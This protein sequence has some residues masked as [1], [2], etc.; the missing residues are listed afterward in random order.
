[1][2]ISIKGTKAGITFGK[3]QGFFIRKRRPPM[4]WFWS[5]LFPEVDWDT[6]AFT[7]G[8]TIY[9]MNPLD[10]RLTAHEKM[11]VRQQKYSRVF[12]FFCIL[13]YKFSRSY[14]KRCELE[15]HRAELQFRSKE[16][17]AKSLSG[18]LY[19]VMT[20]EEALSAL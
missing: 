17:V 19:G 16:E 1:M 7:W 5:F 13:L 4:M 15:A 14:R 10:A 3:A 6:V 8:D 11:H 20:Y 12:G 2:K 9:S 18:S